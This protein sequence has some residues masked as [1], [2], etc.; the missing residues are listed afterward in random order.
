MRNIVLLLVVFVTG[1][2][3]GY[4]APENKNTTLTFIMPDTANA[5]ANQFYSLH[6]NESCAETEGFGMAANML[7]MFGI[8]GFDKTVS[9]VP[10]KRVYIA[11]VGQNHSGGS[12]VYSRSCLNFVS[13]EPTLGHQ[14]LVEQKA[15]GRHCMVEIKENE[16]GKKPESF[17]IHSIPA[18]CH[19]K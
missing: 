11:A 2:A 19:G 6:E 13:F 1:C 5:N 7:K 4:K 14:Y 15:S 3:T 17:V 16:T 10:S 12:T 9:V 18:D 8:G